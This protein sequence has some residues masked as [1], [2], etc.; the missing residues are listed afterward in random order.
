MSD[1]KTRKKTS[2]ITVKKIAS[3]DKDPITL[4]SH[5]ARTCYSATVPE[6]GDIMNVED[7]H[8]AGHNTIFEHNY[9]TFHI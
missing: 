6:M 3:T 4:A 9:Y 5:A 2:P 7:P 8:R 1:V